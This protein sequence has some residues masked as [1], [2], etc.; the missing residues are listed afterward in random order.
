MFNENST[1]VK[2]WVRLIK[3]G[4]YN[5]DAVPKLFNLQTVTYEV[6]DS[7]EAE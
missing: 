1:L 3:G 4:V 5:R 2:L 6:L 7:L